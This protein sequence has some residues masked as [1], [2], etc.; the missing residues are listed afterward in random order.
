[1]KIDNSNTANLGNV[2]LNKAAETEAAS[3]AKEKQGTVATNSDADR[4]SLSNLSGT[5]RAALTESPEREA[6]IEQLTADVASGRY[7][8]DSATI[9]KDIVNDA[10]NK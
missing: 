9:S 6:K 8:V 1:M 5:L 3:Q 4:V 7:H 10:F 2:S